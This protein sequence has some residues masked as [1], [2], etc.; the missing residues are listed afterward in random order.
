MLVCAPK[1]TTVLVERICSI[2]EGSSSPFSAEENSGED[3]H[4]LALRHGKQPGHLV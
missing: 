3:D 2:I 1:L 4:A